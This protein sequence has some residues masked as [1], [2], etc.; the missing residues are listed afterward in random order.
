M[1]QQITLSAFW[2]GFRLTDLQVPGATG[3]S[4]LEFD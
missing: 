1:S 4:R 2:P 3:D